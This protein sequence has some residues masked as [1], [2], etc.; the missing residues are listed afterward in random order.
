MRSDWTSGTGRRRTGPARSSSGATASPPRYGLTVTASAPRRSKRATACRATVVPMSPRL[1][2]RTT[3]RSDGRLARM[4]SSAANPSDPKASK[5]ARFGLIAAA[6]GAAASTSRRANRST[7]RRSG[8]NPSGRAAGSGS[9][10]THRTL[11]TDA[12]RAASRSRYV[13]VMGPAPRRLPRSGSRSGRASAVASP[14][15]R[16]AGCTRPVATRRRGPDTWV[17]SIV[18]VTVQSGPD[19]PSLASLRSTIWPSMWRNAMASP[20]GDQTGAHDP[21]SVVTR[22]SS[23]PWAASRITTSLP[24]LLVRVAAM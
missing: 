13:I 3:G 6:T 4:R 11:P 19:P 16:P 22:S 23:R 21:P 12:D 14:A 10:P 9:R 2:S 17:R 5:K 1:P 24:K 15:A 8:E 7:P 18:S 20:A